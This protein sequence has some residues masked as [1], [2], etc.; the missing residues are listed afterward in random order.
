MV[1]TKEV[2]GVVK[3]FIFSVFCGCCVTS[4]TSFQSQLFVSFETKKRSGGNTNTFGAQFKLVKY[5]GCESEMQKNTH[6]KIM[7][8]N[9]LLR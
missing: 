9:I 5:G 4:C 2:V 6:E 7:N 3:G 8:G 1:Q